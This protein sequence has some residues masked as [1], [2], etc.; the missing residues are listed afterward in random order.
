MTITKILVPITNR[1]DPK[2][3][4]YTK[5]LAREN[6]ASLTILY[7]TSPLTLTN[8]YAYP[9]MLYS[10]ANMNLDSIQVAHETLAEQ[11]DT[12]IGDFPHETLC[13]VGPTTDTILR[14]AEQKGIDF[15]VIPGAPE[16]SSGKFMV[17]P[18]SDKLSKKTSIP[19]MI[20]NS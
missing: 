4:Q 18:K 8:Y 15:I 14:I 7:I 1:I 2:L 16:T 6:N 5:D 13:L 17:K 10:I 12:L 9:S 3:L 19:V 20:Y 11:I